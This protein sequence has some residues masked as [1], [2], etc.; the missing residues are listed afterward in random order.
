MSFAIKK[1]ACLEAKFTEV[2]Q[3]HEGSVAKAEKFWYEIECVP[4]LAKEAKKF[5]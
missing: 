5:C 4:R 1:G 2:L 3:V